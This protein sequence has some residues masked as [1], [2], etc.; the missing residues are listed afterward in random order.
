MDLCI[1]CPGEGQR[2]GR[3]GAELA[4]HLGTLPSVC[5]SSPNERVLSDELGRREKDGRGYI[6]TLQPLTDFSSPLST[7][8][9]L[10]PHRDTPSTSRDWASQQ[11]TSC[12][13]LPPLSSTCI[14]SSF[15]G[16]WRLH[17]HPPHHWKRSLSKESQGWLRVIGG[18]GGEPRDILCCEACPSPRW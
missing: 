13:Y 18:D 4:V 11:P 15:H 10:L 3:A 6:T 8:S 2:G 16:S 1:V 17:L 5:L 12:N 14:S 9:C 7:P